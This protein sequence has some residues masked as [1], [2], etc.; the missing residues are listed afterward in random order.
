M[1]ATLYSAS[2]ASSSKTS[3]GDTG[4][5]SPERERVRRVGCP[6]ATQVHVRGTPAVRGAI[7]R[8]ATAATS[9]LLQSAWKVAREA[10]GLARLDLD[11]LLV[12]LPVRG[13]EDDGVG[14]GGQRDGVRLRHRSPA[15]RLAS[16]DAHPRGRPRVRPPVADRHK[17]RLRGTGAAGDGG[18]GPRGPPEGGRKRHVH[19][20]PRPADPATVALLTLAA[21]GL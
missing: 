9:R 19:P 10:R 12:A 7:P 1:F 5:P 3:H 17:G 2:A 8:G 16:V 21:P 15:A 4:C 20:A 14:A 11:R 18:R 13:L 6:D